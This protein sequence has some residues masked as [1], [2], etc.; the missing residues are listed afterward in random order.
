MKT[1]INAFKS[2]WQKVRP[3]KTELAAV[4]F[5]QNL[6]AGIKNNPRILKQIQINPEEAAEK[7]VKIL[8]SDS[9]RLLKL[10]DGR[11]TP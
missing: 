7:A 3:D 11:N 8:G 1:I 6:L 9:Q 10:P 2:F 4:I 5:A